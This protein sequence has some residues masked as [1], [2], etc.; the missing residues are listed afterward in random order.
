[1]H[2]DP[3]R[4][5][6]RLAAK[7]WIRV[8]LTAD[9]IHAGPGQRNVDAGGSANALPGTSR[10]VERLDDRLLDAVHQLAHEESG[11]SQVDQRVDHDLARSVVGDLAAAIGRHH[12]NGRRW[13][14]DVRAG[15]LW[16][17]VYTGE[18]S[19]THSSSGVVASRRSV[20]SRIACQVCRYSARPHSRT[21]ITKRPFT[22][23]CASAPVDRIELARDCARTLRSAKGTCRRAT[24]GP[25][26]CSGPGR[27]RAAH[28]LD[29]LRLEIQ[30]IESHDLDRK[31]RREHQRTGRR[32]GSPAA[33]AQSSPPPLPSSAAERRRQLGGAEQVALDKVLEA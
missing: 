7:P 22:S 33:P 23:G 14:A 9:R 10:D 21:R 29:D 28:K 13:H 25:R 18:C 24:V 3:Q 20:N 12:R 2:L 19:T 8:R 11:A 30:V 26:S 16:P 1:M 5:D 4:G 31:I 32:F 15:R 27:G 6:L 17:R